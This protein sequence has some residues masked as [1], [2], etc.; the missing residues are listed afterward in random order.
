[1]V[2]RHLKIIIANEAK[3]QLREAYRYISKDSEQNAGKVLVAILN[4]IKDL[5]LFSK[6]YS[7]DKYKLNNDGNFMAYEIYKYRISYHISDEQITILRVR[8]VRMNPLQY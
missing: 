3:K 6:K 7:P 5:I 2:K 8:H 4:S 1:M